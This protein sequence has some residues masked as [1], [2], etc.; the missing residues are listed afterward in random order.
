MLL[1]D[2]DKKSSFALCDFVET[3]PSVN[4][5]LGKKLF[6]WIT[7]VIVLYDVISDCVQ[8]GVYY[9]EFGTASGDKLVDKVQFMCRNGTNASQLQSESGAR[10]RVQRT[11][12]LYFIAASFGLVLGLS[13]V[14]LQWV[15]KSG[16][17]AFFQMK[18]LPEGWKMLNRMSRS[19]HI[20]EDHT[21]VEVLIF[22]LTLL[23]EDLPATI[24]NFDII[25]NTCV[26][27]HHVNVDVFV[28]ASAIG[29]ALGA[30]RS[31]CIYSLHLFFV[32]CPN[33]FFDCV[34]EDSWT[35]CRKFFCY[36]IIILFMVIWHIYVAPVY[37]FIL[38]MWS[39][40]LC[41]FRLVQPL[42]SR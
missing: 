10:T 16:L 20:F 27:Q 23:L 30:F 36:P 28:I 11:Y 7:T 13:G 3:T 15:D 41:F 37:V 32:S 26:R 4:M 35:T 31:L 42:R 39:F 25:L 1:T 21:V 17:P 33:C 38:G 40:F 2:C 8:A 22:Q 24:A 6:R 9:T 34:P 18:K 12:I 29:S 14:A 5:G 19:S